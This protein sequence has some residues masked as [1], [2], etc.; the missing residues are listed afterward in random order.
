MQVDAEFASV[1][2]SGSEASYDLRAA[3]TQRL[4]STVLCKEIWQPFYFG[5]TLLHPEQISLLQAVAIEV[6]GSSEDNSG[7]HR[8]NNIWRTV[9]MRALQ[10]L[11]SSEKLPQHLQQQ[12]AGS[13]SPPIEQIV[14]DVMSRLEVLYRPSQR[15]ELRTEL[16]NLFNSA[17][18]LWA[19]AQ[20]DAL[21]ISAHFILDLGQHADWSSQLFD[22]QDSDHTDDDA[23][24]PKVFT[25]FPQVTAVSSAYVRTSAASLPGSW[26]E[27]IANTQQIET[28][29]HPGL[30]FLST[31][32]LVT[33][34]KDEMENRNAILRDA[35]AKANVE[36]RARNV[37]RSRRD[38][39]VGSQSQSPTS[40]WMS[41]GGK[42][43]SS[44]D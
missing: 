20:T 23:L 41:H 19:T 34:G 17:M 35:L 1:P 30:G 18:F 28:S 39:V 15:A 16:T 11:S 22:T 6:A 29:I 43:F 36:L 5:Y 44:E 26:P 24:H 38:S 9:T 40:R 25:L 8:I 33:A 4:L 10:S 3:H 42:K 31:S 12:A 27:S 13:A 32:A 7:G 2:I 14:K 37:G 21:Q